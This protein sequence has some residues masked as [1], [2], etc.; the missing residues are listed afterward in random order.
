[1]PSIESTS[2]D[3][4]TRYAVT[5]VNLLQ[6]DARSHHNLFHLSSVLNSSVRVGVKRLDKNAATPAGQS[7]N[8]ESSRIINAQQSGLDT[9]AS[10]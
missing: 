6:R 7:G 5:V 3:R 8:H 2:I 9:D 10:G 1:M 4:P